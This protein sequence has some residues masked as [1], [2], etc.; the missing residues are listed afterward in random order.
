[1]T[2]LSNSTSE[3]FLYSSGSKADLRYSEI[4][5]I[6]IVMFGIALVWVCIPCV[7]TFIQKQKIFGDPNDEEIAMS[8]LKGNDEAEVWLLIQFKLKPM[9]FDKKE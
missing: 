2:A 7:C 3:N 8:L 4:F 5:S 6:T 9:I 1:M